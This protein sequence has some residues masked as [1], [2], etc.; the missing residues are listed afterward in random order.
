MS[1]FQ[2]FVC[3]QEWMMRPKLPSPSRGLPTPTAAP[4]SLL[5]LTFPCPLRHQWRRAG[6]PRS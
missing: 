6:S 4:P 5:Q 1:S 3:L 2:S